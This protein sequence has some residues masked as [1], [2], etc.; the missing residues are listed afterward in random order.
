MVY[1]IHAECA[2]IVSLTAV[3]ASKLYYGSTGAATA[4]GTGTTGDFLSM[5]P[6]ALSSTSAI[7]TLTVTRFER[8]VDS[9]SNSFDPKLIAQLELPSTSAWVHLLH[10]FLSLVVLLYG[11]PD[12]RE[13]Q[14]LVSFG[15]VVHLL[16]FAVMHWNYIHWKLIYWNWLSVAIGV[17]L[18]LVMCLRIHSL[19]MLEDEDDDEDGDGISEQDRSTG[20]LGIMLKGD[21]AGRV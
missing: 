10:I 21:D 1:L 4:T 19:L 8:S 9:L 14:A 6:T 18:L 17:G 15:D 2:A 16:V 5:I 3:A 20:L 11:R 12:Q 7:T 13:E